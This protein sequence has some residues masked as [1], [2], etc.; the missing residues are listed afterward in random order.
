M[1]NLLKV[2]YFC[3][4]T[5]SFLGCKKTSVPEG[6]Y[7]F[8]YTIVTTD[9]I[10]FNSCPV[11]NVYL[12]VIESNKTFIVFAS[13]DTLYKEGTNVFGTFKS[14]G[15]ISCHGNN[16]F[17]G[18][19]HLTG[20]SRKEKGIHYISGEITTIVYGPKQINDVI[21]WDTV[22]AKGTFEIKSNF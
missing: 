21:I 10:T 7:S 14:T 3:L 13:N 4:L 8:E 6:A 20:T 16:R 5:I 1:R 15:A 17:F 9:S 12:D 2:I 22:N 11:D 18:E 19:K